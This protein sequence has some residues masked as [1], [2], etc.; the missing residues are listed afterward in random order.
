LACV[1][2]KIA[3]ME[4]LPERPPP[5]FVGCL[6]GGGVDAI[7]VADEHGI[8]ERFNKAAESM[9]G[10]TAD[11]AIGQN[12]T[13]LMPQSD[14]GSHDNYMSR[15]METGERKIIG[16]G[17]EV[18]ALRK[19]GS[20]FSADLAIG[21]VSWQD[22]H[23]FVGLIRDLTEKKLA[24]ERAIL[25]REEMIQASRVT[26]MGEMAASM[27]HEL[28]QPLTAI[29]NYASACM[30][31][32]RGS[33]PKI[34]A[35]SSAL[36]SI[37]GQAHRA[38]EVIRRLRDF[39][40]YDATTRETASCADLVKE[41]LPLANVDAKAHNIVF[42]V[43]VPNDLPEIRVDS[44]QLQQVVLNLL[45]NGIDAMDVAEPEDRHLYLV[46]S[47]EGKDQVRIDVVDR[48]TGVSEANMSQLFD[49]FFTTKSD[50]MGMGLAICRTIVHSHGGTLTCVNNEDRGATFTIR[51]PTRLE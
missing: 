7:I 16:I 23:R 51:L 14:K 50:G 19:D 10:Y 26:T 15:Y 40:R 32:L 27:A 36:E 46:G 45:R 21:E 13:L 47:S 48:G 18:V 29:A 9:F 39:V 28:N 6:G 42:H 34:E 24:E 41:I 30:R 31:L 38:S 37:N 8:I 33:N 1:L 25:R 5:V 12:I 2:P 20:L 11:E 22:Q 3:K 17:R 35:V 4:Q 49:A 43:D 44:L